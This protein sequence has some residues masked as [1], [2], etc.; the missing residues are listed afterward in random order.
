M[1][2]LRKWTLPMLGS[3]LLAFMLAGCGSLPSSGNSPFQPFTG[4]QAHGT[5]TQGTQGNGNGDGTAPAKMA[6]K[7]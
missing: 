5:N 2:Q 6:K 1:F 7:A 3:S 4:G